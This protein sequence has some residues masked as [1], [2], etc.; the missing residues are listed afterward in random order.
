VWGKRD[1][2]IPA[3]VGQA[4][5]DAIPGARLELLDTGHAPHVSDPAGVA[6]IL[7][8]FLERALA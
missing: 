1:P 6:A 3:K 2:V 5:A 4:L 8:P 7:G